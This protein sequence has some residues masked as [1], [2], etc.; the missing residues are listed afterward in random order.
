MSPDPNCAFF[1]AIG[2]ITV[3][4]LRSPLPELPIGLH[5]AIEAK[6]SIEGV[7]SLKSREVASTVLGRFRHLSGIY[8]RKR[9]AVLA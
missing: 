3:L 4:H 2:S 8:V 9:R 6:R 1:D 7:R 5:D